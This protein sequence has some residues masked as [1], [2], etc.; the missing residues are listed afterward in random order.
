MDLPPE[1]YH[2]IIRAAT[3][4]HEALDTSYEAITHEDRESIKTDVADSIAVKRLLCL[5]SKKFYDLTEEYIY[6]IITLHRFDHIPRV[7]KS[8]STSRNGKSPGRWCR[9][10]EICLGRDCDDGEDWAGSYILWGL[11]PSCPNVAVFV[12]QGWCKTGPSSHND[13]SLISSVVL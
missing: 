9:R 3:Y 6:E 2:L 8:I 4:I 12:F 11:L 7:V 10:L 13:A 5:V 1:I